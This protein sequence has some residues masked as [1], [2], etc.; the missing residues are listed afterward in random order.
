LEK[1]AFRFSLLWNCIT[2]SLSVLDIAQDLLFVGCWLGKFLEVVV[3]LVGAV[4]FE[5]HLVY[6]KDGL[7]EAQAFSPCFV[8][9][10]SL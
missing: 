2:F 7:F 3:L 6:W 4:A 8:C 9:E 10:L 1:I 5:G